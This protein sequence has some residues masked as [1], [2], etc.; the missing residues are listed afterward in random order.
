MNSTT[1]AHATTTGAT[2][3]NPV[4]GRDF[5]D[6]FIL[7]HCGE[8]WAYSTGF[9]RDG[10]AF[11]VMHSRDLVNW[12]ELA[13]ALA[14]LAGEHPCYWAPEVVY[15]NGRFLMYY[16]VGNERRMHIRVAVADN[17][18]GP[19][20]DSGHE[21]TDA[22]FA[23]D[24]HVFV[25][26]DGTR[27]LFY[28]TDFLTHTHIGTGTVRD[29]LLDHFT[30]AREPRPVTRARYDWQVYDPAREEKG[31]VRWHTVEGPFVLRRKNLYYQMF[32]G[33]NW[34][35]LTYGVS[36]AVSDRIAREDEWEQT[37]DGERVLPILRT[38]PERVVGPGHN[39]VVR[40]R[41]NV[42]LF[43]VYHRWDGERGRVLAIDRLDFVGER[44]TVLGAT[45]TPQPAP[46]PPTFAGFE[47]EHAE[48]LGESWTCA[49]GRWSVYDG[50]A[51][52]SA[53]AQGAASARCGVRASSFVLEVSL[54]A[55]EDASV[56]GAFGVALFG[57]DVCVLRFLLEPRALEARVEWQANGGAQAEDGAHAETRFALPADFEPRAFHLLRVV[58]D[59]GFVTIFLDERV[60]RWQGT[61]NVAPD[62]AAL[63]TEGAA[64]S[65]KGFE[66]TIGW[67]ELFTQP[68]RSLSA[69]GWQRVGGEGEEGWRL[70]DGLLRFDDAEGSNRIITRG[71]LLEAYELVVNVRLE[72]E[73]LRGTGC[74][75]FYPAYSDGGAS[76]HD[77]LFTVERDGGEGSSRWALVIRSLKNT[78]IAE[79]WPLPDAFDP[80]TMQQF[81]FRKQGGRL[82]IQ[83]EATPLGEI[84]TTRE[85][86]GVGLYAH[87]ATVAYDMVRVTGTVTSDK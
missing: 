64:A 36:Y 51:R 40:G 87:R 55:E 83:C 2:Y 29:L 3:L 39:S 9:W 28:A 85:A 41:D 60:V 33:G 31:G 37:A 13:G 30:L 15:E 43:C 80:F 79:S 46:T 38:I 68:E 56:E 45:T 63:V 22:E 24:P 10:R 44:M 76:E 27:W 16:S 48:S 50:E 66:L 26:E 71:P 84:N 70:E 74:Y 11:G 82:S 17:P 49:G 23:I 73:H 77:P 52:Q 18:A 54:R 59:E 57:G 58:V 67:E 19:F 32:S 72:Q 69:R 53:S 42:Q 21:L 1:D 78:S 47:G 75:G 81:R 34:Q 20:E 62:S 6:P 25:D 4:Y 5:P 7:K 86:T 65:F 12:R 35:N 14:P 8:Y 61:P